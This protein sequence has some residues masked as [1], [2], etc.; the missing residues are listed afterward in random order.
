MHASDAGQVEIG[1]SKRRSNTH[2]SVDPATGCTPLP[3]DLGRRRQAMDECLK[4]EVKPT[5]KWQGK[6]GRE[7]VGVRRTLSVRERTE[8]VRS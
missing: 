3:Y 4:V 6:S 2:G 5:D 8:S 1:S 7:K